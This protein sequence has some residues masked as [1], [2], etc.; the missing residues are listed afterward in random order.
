MDPIELNLTIGDNL[1]ARRAWLT[2][3]PLVLVEVSD[4]A[5]NQCRSRLDI[6]KHVFLDAVPAQASAAGINLLIETVIT[7]P[8]TT[9]W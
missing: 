9:R 8:H 4:K 5:G 2:G 3:G 7:E 1:L 6:N